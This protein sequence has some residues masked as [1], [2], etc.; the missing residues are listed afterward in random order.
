[1]SANSTVDT[2]P[3]TI[4]YDAPADGDADAA[5]LLEL[6]YGVSVALELIADD[7]GAAA[8]AGW[9]Q[10]HVDR[11]EAAFR[12]GQ[13]LLDSPA[14]EAFFQEGPAALAADL[15][16][17]LREDMA[18]LTGLVGVDVEFFADGAGGGR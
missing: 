12:T 15:Q 3:I 5:A 16:D 1:M 18:P 17:D 2:P 9:T 11:L 7:V 13:R 10:A 14:F 8:E 6:H 4:D